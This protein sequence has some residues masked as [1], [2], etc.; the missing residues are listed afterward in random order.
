MEKVSA[1]KTK[2][3]EPVRWEKNGRGLG[4]GRQGREVFQHLDQLT[5]ITYH[6]VM[7]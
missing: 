4:D 3:E 5:V 2:K 7:E 6:C 1:K